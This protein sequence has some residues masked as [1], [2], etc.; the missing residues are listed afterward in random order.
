MMSIYPI[1]HIQLSFVQ[2]SL[3]CYK[4]CILSKTECK[5]IYYYFRRDHESTSFQKLARNKWICQETYG[6]CRDQFTL[7]AINSIIFIEMVIQMFLLNF[8]LCQETIVVML[9]DNSNHMLNFDIK[10]VPKLCQ[11]LSF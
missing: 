2:F 11:H 3:L 9:I 6:F 7:L 10:D 4:F 8:H 5:S 1:V